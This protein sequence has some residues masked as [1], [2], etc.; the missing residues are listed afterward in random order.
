MRK[1]KLCEEESCKGSTLCFD[2]LIKHR[3][4]KQKEYNK[5]AIAKQREQI[6]KEKRKEKKANSPIR[7]KNKADKLWREKVIEW[8]GNKCLVCGS[9]KIN[10]HHLVSRAN[11]ATRW[12]IPNGVP[13]CA[14]HHTFG[15]QSAHQHPFWFRQFMF[16]LRGA[17]W[18]KDLIKKSNEVWDR[19]Y[20]VVEPN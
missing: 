15:S 11:R 17:K 19:K 12:Y 9:D 5:K 16:D 7:L 6:R 3:A 10:I 18:E 20:E 14:L 8:Y 2:H 1:C 13:L 4:L